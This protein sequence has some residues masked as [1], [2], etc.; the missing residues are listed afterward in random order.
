MRSM[1]K[2]KAIS[3]LLMLI[4]LVPLFAACT[5]NSTERVYPYKWT[6]S[7]D[8]EILTNDDN[9]FY[10]Y[11]I[12]AGYK[13]D[14]DPIY[15]YKNSVEVDGYNEYIYSYTRKGE[16]VAFDNYWSSYST[17]AL[18]CYVTD[19]GERI[20]DGLVDGTSVRPHI[21]YDYCLAAIDVEMLERLDSVTSGVSVDVTELRYLDRYD[22]RLYDET[23]S[24]YRV[25][26]A[27]YEYKGALWYLNY[28]KLS[29]DKFSSDG[30]FSYRSGEVTIYELI[31]DPKLYYDIN[32]A[33]GAGEELSGEWIRERKDIR[34][35]RKKMD[36]DVRARVWFWI[37]YS[38]VNLALPAW[39]FVIG[40]INAHSKKHGKSRYWLIQSLA[41]LVWLLVGIVIALLLIFG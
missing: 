23:R 11:D 7:E 35:E 6:I 2:I 33:I 9:V 3:V 37:S 10:K 40:I 27:L 26:G 8:Y 4:I 29:N 17:S 13:L 38:I 18:D 19:E 25:C 22:I 32:E 5:Q 41:A 21:Y 31:T 16:I 24:F 15:A 34:P 36:P 28:D 30:E 14:F 39:P 12:P 20:L 1:F